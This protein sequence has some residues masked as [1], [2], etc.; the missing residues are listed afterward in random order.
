VRSPTAQAH[1]EQLASALWE[2]S[3]TLAGLAGAGAV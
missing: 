1:D 3:E 2:R